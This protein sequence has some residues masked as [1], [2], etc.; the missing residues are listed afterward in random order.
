MA[1]DEPKADDDVQDNN[2][3]TFVMDGQTADI[4]RQ[5]GGLTIDYIDEAS[6][7]GYMLKLGSAGGGCSSG[8]CDSGGCG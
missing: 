6:R 1:L 4:L 2:G 8:S 3:I 7:R 5:S